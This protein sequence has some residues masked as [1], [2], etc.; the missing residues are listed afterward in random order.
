[1]PEDALQMIESGGTIEIALNGSR[2]LLLANY[3]VSEIRDRNI[4]LIL[5]HED[6]TWTIPPANLQP[7]RAVLRFYEGAPTGLKVQPGH[8]FPVYTTAIY[9]NGAI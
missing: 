8:V 5:A 2:S 9:L 1:M 3:Q 4:T 7:G 6:V